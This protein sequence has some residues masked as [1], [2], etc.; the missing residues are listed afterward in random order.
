[1]ARLFLFV[2]AE[3]EVPRGTWR[4][5]TPVEG[6]TLGY[7]GC[8]INQLQVGLAELPKA[9]AMS[10]YSSWYH[11]LAL[12]LGPAIIGIRGQGSMT[13]ECSAMSTPPVIL[14]YLQCG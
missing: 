14:I 9:R 4:V 6:T 12:L 8:A 10:K 13:M 5:V 2:G 7:P 11:E 1:M 3:V